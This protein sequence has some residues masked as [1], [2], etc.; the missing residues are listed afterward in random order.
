MRAAEGRGEGGKV[1]LPFRGLAELLAEFT[2]LIGM[3]EIVALGIDDVKL[4]AGPGRRQDMS[5]NPA[6]I[7]VEDENAEGLSVR[8]ENRSPDPQHGRAG[9]ASVAVIQ[10]DGR[11]IDLPRR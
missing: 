6:H 5:E 8:R 2:R 11:D 3:N 1:S 7:D 10:L 4:C 9:I